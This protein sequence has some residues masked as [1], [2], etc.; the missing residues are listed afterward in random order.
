M[1]PASFLVLSPEELVFRSNQKK[2]VL[3][4][5]IELSVIDLHPL[6]RL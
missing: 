1:L 3:G 6:V 5:R 2:S 4:D